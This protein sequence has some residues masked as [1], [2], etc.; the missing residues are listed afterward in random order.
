MG[1]RWSDRQAK[2]HPWLLG[3][4]GLVILRPR[5][6]DQPRTP[7]RKHCTFAEPVPMKPPCTCGKIVRACQR[8]VCQV[9]FDR[10]LK[11][12]P[13]PRRPT[14]THP[15]CN[16]EWRKARLPFRRSFPSAGAAVQPPPSCLTAATIAF[17]NRANWQPLCGFCHNQPKQRQKRR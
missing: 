16:H 13:D 2:G 10:A 4:A 5:R 7:S 9:V 6:R 1:A 3:L 12:R 17:N 8:C 14:A 15:G 11:A